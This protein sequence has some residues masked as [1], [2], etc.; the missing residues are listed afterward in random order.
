METKTHHI[1]LPGVNGR[2]V[3]LSGV[4]A[5]ENTVTSH[6]LEIPCGASYTNWKGA[7]KADTPTGKV[8]WNIETNGPF[9]SL[10]KTSV[11]RCTSSPQKVHV[12]RTLIT[13]RRQTEE[14]K[15]PGNMAITASIRDKVID[16]TSLKLNPNWTS[17]FLWK[18][19]QTSTSVPS[20]DTTGDWPCTEVYV[21]DA[22]TGNPTSSS[23]GETQSPEKADGRTKG[24][25]GLTGNRRGRKRSRT[26]LTSTE[27]KAQSSSTNSRQIKR[28]LTCY[29][30]GWTD[31]RFLFPSKEDSPHSWQGRLLSPPRTTPVIGT[32]VCLP[33]SPDELTT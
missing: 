6:L 28:R 7:L 2:G 26:G 15:V 27:E 13:A 16:L 32:E 9:T 25:L 22:E 12:N 19:L 18:P 33:N 14:S 4:K 24:T 1:E 17:E 29:Y 20:S 3:L 10:K 23:S 30:D 21:A 31:T 5:K 11:E 8:M